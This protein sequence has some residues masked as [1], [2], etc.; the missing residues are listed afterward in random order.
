MT[1]HLTVSKKKKNLP[2]DSTEPQPAT[3]FGSVAGY[4]LFHL[5]H[6]IQHSPTYLLDW[7]FGLYMLFYAFLIEPIIK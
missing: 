1:G 3:D 4:L 5:S 7:I 6:Y 2:P